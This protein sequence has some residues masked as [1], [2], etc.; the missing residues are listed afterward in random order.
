MVKHYNIDFIRYFTRRNGHGNGLIIK[1]GVGTGKTTLLSLIVKLLLDYSNFAIVTN[2]RFHPDVYEKYTDRI[3]YVAN[4]RQYFNFYIRV[5]YSQPILL[6]WD[7]SQGND[8]FTSKGVMSDGGKILSSFLIYLRKFSTSYI[9]IA[10]QSYLPRSI[11]EG[12]EPYYIYKI[13][14]ENFVISKNFYEMDSDSYSDNEN[15]ICEMLSFND[16]DENY[17]PILSHAFT[18]FI[19]NVNWYDL[20]QFLSQYEV[21]ENLK[22]YVKI[23]F[24][25][26][27]KSE[28]KKENKIEF[29]KNMSYHDYYLGLCLKRNKEIKESTPLNDIINNNTMSRVKKQ[30]R[31]ENLLK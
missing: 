13:E 10:H 20:K 1:G 17:L 12:F 26:I 31:K 2:V 24:E 28:S 21:G 6:I 25:T 16:F 8:E 9:Y 22:K 14:R 18:D 27:E 11:V 30:I 23:Y 29:L 3:F 5:P 7:D 19:F 15:V 4:V